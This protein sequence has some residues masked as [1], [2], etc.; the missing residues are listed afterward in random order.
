M[1]VES[2]SRTRWLDKHRPAGTPHSCVSPSSSLFGSHCDWP[3]MSDATS[4]EKKRLVAILVD[5][6]HEYRLG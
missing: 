3:F 2:Y 4:F 1:L 6:Q 5:D